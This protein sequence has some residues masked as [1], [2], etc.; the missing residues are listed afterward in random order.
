MKRYAFHYIFMYF[1]NKIFDRVML[2][3]SDQGLLHA[4]RQGQRWQD[5]RAGPRPRHQVPGAKPHRGGSERHRQ[6]YDSYVV[7]ML[8][9]TRGLQLKFNANHD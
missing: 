6:K 4:L 7:L 5:R 9:A 8:C 3:R 2:C 1:S